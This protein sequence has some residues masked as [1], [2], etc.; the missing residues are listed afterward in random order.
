MAHIHRNA[1]VLMYTSEECGSRVLPDHAFEKDTAARM[2]VEHRRNI[3]DVA[4][5]QDKGSAFRLSLV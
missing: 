4:G 2:P 3:M 1:C 5:N